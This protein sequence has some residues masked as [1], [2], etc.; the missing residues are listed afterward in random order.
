MPTISI[1]VPDELDRSMHEFKVDWSDVA[2]RAI[3]EKAEKLK[4]L[5]AFSS[6]A[7]VSDRDAK[8]FTDKIS[9]SVARRFKEAK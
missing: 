8:E 4:K 1:K 9:E 6:K 3:F 5:K 2:L 7:S